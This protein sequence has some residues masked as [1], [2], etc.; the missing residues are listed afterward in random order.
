MQTIEARRVPLLDLRSQF[1]QIRDE[2][3]A[4]I[5][6]ICE[7]QEF[8]LGPTVQKFEQA[9]ASYSSVPYAIGC[10]SGSDALTL[11]LM[12]HDIGPGDKVLTVPFTFFATAGSI[13]QLGAIPVF[14][15]VDPET[16]NIDVRKA[17]ELMDS[18]DGI[19]AIIPV[20]LY[21]GCADMAPLCAAAAERKIPVIEDAAQ[22][23]G[24]EYLG[25]RAGSLGTIGC[26]S[27]YPTKNL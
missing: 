14:V 16:A 17:I 13:T 1:T 20:H 2:T 27:F 22:S 26:F 4:E 3:M 11:A 15:D 9:M 21:G 25:Q 8:I 10:A 7:S 18:T 24:A 12:A 5:S 23:I 6:R 19:R